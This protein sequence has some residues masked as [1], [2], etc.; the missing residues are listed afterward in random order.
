MLVLIFFVLLINTKLALA[1]VQVLCDIKTEED[2]WEL[3]EDGEIEFEEYESLIYLYQHPTDINRPL[4][5]DMNELFQLLNLAPEVLQDSK[6]PVMSDA[7]AYSNDI[8][9]KLSDTA[10]DSKKA[11]KFI[12]GHFQPITHLKFSGLINNTSGNS[13]VKKGCI[14]YEQHRLK[15]VL[16]NYQAIFGQGIVFNTTHRNSIDTAGDV[17]SVNEVAPEEIVPDDTTRANNIN[18]GFVLTTEVKEALQSTIFYSNVNLQEFKNPILKEFDNREE[19]FGANLTLDLGK[20]VELGCTGYQSEFSDKQGKTKRIAVYGIGNIT[21]WKNHLRY[22]SLSLEAAKSSEDGYGLIAQGLLFTDNIRFQTIFCRYDKDFITPHGV[23]FS[24]FRKKIG[25]SDK[26]GISY[27]IRYKPTK[28]LTLETRYG[29][30]KQLSNLTTNEEFWSSINYKINKGLTIFCRFKI[31]DEDILRSY[32]KKR[33]S[34]IR[35]I[36][37]PFSKIDVITNWKRT[38]NDGDSIINDYFYIKTTYLV[39]PNLMLTGRVKYVDKPIDDYTEGY[40]QLSYTGHKLQ[41]ANHKLTASKSKELLIRHTCTIKEN[42]KEPNPV[43]KSYLRIK[44]K[45]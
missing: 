32:D 19:L 27:K 14:S 15:A 12:R 40:L 43:H 41:I 17:L 45:W 23:G 36:L 3:F 30:D 13:E 8:E 7:K 16:G 2:I 25:D 38:D 20:K 22:L 28:S 9:L 21:N 37:K 4:L 6:P 29:H 39:S 34:T 1:S 24:V 35:F 5:T 18:N 42:D 26:T 33:D 44:I 10:D 11:S 31:K